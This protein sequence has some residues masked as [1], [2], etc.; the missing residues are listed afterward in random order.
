M[1]QY[2]K[3]RQ[4]MVAAQIEKRGIRDP[5]VLAALKKIPRHRFVPYEH[6]NLSYQDEA[7]A[8]EHCQTIS[9]PY[10]VAYMSEMLKLKPNHRVLEIGTGS[11]YQ[12]AVLAELAKEVFTIERI[13]DLSLLAQATLNELGYANI[14]FKVDDGALG[15]TRFQPFDAIVVTASAE[16]VPQ[17]LIDQLA[18]GGRLIIPVGTTEQRL[19]LI[20]RTNGVAQK[21]L[22]PV[23][24]VPLITA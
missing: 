19:I 21:H 24:F 7:L 5:L 4:E 10:I 11:G 17:A 2:E 12:T 23:R 13:E 6:R 22:L 20:Q 3:A 15:W 16:E 9:Q 8:I 1:E 14:V 18:V